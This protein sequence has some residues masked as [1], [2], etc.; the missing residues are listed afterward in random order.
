MSATKT[1]SEAQDK[2]PAAPVVAKQP[3]TPE[4]AS[5]PRHVTP[6]TSAS[7]AAPPPNGTST[8]ARA[9]EMLTSKPDLNSGKRASMIR[10]LQR[11]VGN[12]RV[13]TLLGAVQTKLAVGAVDD[14]HEREA[15]QV[16]E[17]MTQPGKK[18]ATSVQRRSVMKQPLIRLAKAQSQPGEKESVDTKMEQRIQ[19]PGSGKPLPEG[20]RREMETGLGA[21]FS[22]VRVHDNA[23]NQADAG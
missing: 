7:A 19:S 14:P 18:P 5:G 20:M 16:A 11:S 8:P 2:A 3:E 4:K 22:N 6:A 17:T 1:L 13:S 23:A 12:N 10:T 9:A 21:D 15:D